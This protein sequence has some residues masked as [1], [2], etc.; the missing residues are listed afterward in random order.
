MAH[1]DYGWMVD[2]VARN[3]PTAKWVRLARAGTDRVTIAVRIPER[4]ESD[5]GVRD[6]EAF[7][8]GLHH[9]IWQARLARANRDGETY[10]VIFSVPRQ[11]T[12]D[13]ILKG[14]SK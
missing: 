7:L 14:S 4:R 9:S 3:V 10:E 13:N 8:A 11:L 2:L 12:F 6:I 1:S 5:A